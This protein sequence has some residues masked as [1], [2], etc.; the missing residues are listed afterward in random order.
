M[1]HSVPAVAGV[2]IL[3]GIEQNIRTAESDVINEL[4]KTI[5]KTDFKFDTLTAQVVPDGPTI[6]TVGQQ[7]KANAFLSAFNSK[8]DP[9]ITVSGGSV[10]VEGGEGHLTLGGG[11][12]EHEYNGMISL[13]NPGT[14][15][16]K[17]YPFKGKYQVIKPFGSVSADKMNV[18]YIGVPNPVT[19]TAAGYTADKLVASISSGAIVP[20]PAAG[21]GHYTVTQTANGVAEVTVM[22]KDAK[23]AMNMV[24]KFPFRVKRIP[25]PVAKI[26][27]KQGGDMQATVIKA[28]T[29]VSAILDGFDFDCPFR[30]SKYDCFYIARRQDAKVSTD[31]KSPLFSDQ[32][33][34]WVNTCKPGDIFIFKNMYARGCDNTPRQL[35]DLTITIK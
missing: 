2:T 6:I 12:G 18:V 11:E 14:G 35:A 28:Q 5:G 8:D 13:K 17:K 3:N 9:E 19:I 4:L 22:G 25:D 23:G 27:G 15:E 31:N 30:I 1:F 24:G 29:G 20:D 33:K 7:F 26:G 32:I 21:Q 10:K 34:G 16:V